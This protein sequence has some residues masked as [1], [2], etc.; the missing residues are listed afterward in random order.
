LSGVLA[1]CCLTSPKELLVIAVC[2][3]LAIG[4]PLWSWYR[5]LKMWEEDRRDSSRH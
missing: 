1:L 3:F 5:K 2:G 4:L